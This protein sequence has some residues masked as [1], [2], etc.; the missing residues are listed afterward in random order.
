MDCEKEE[1]ELCD[2][3]DDGDI[4]EGGSDAG[5]GLSEDQDESGSD[6]ESGSVTKILGRRLPVRGSRRTL[7]SNPSFADSLRL[8]KLA[9]LGDGADDGPEPLD[10]STYAAGAGSIGPHGNDPSRGRGGDGRDRDHDN[11]YGGGGAGGVDVGTWEGGDAAARFGGGDDAAVSGSRWPA[12]GGSRGRGAAGS[13]V[14]AAASAAIVIPATSSLRGDAPMAG[15]GANA[16][17]AAACPH[18]RWSA[19]MPDKATMRRGRRRPMGIDLSDHTNLMAS[20]C[21]ICQLSAERQWRVNRAKELSKRADIH[22]E[23][24]VDWNGPAFVPAVVAS[25]VLRA[26][27]KLFTSEQQQNRPVRLPNID[28]PY[29][30]MMAIGGAGGGGGGGGGG[31]AADADAASATGLISGGEASGDDDGDLSAASGDDGTRAA[32]ARSEPIAVTGCAATQ[33]LT[34]TYDARVY[35]FCAITGDPLAAV[36]LKSWGRGANIAT[37]AAGGLAH[38]QINHAGRTTAIYKFK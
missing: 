32:A 26:Q 9:S 36:R 8:A 13:S 21:L 17:N 34:L 23:T 22:A 31:G 2:L 16:A 14:S 38:V 24:A 19:D 28:I 30:G 25:A 11:G 33:T 4:D 3:M 7:R 5:S 29:A 6:S 18:R 27:R 10:P 20:T 12:T 1:Q 35:A 37:L 15:T